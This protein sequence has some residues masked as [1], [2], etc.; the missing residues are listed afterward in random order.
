MDAFASA[1]VTSMHLQIKWC[2][3][4]DS[5]S[6]GKAMIISSAVL[7]VFGAVAPRAAAFPDSVPS[8]Y[9]QEK[10]AAP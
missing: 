5:I 7:S 1:R 8:A 4:A 6:A 2:V 10:P 9:R 3:P